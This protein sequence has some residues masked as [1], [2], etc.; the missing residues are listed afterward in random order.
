MSKLIS[1]KIKY[2]SIFKLDP[3]L[4]YGSF[5]GTADVISF[6]SSTLM[7]V[8]SNFGFETF[9]RFVVLPPGTNHGLY[10]VPLFGNPKQFSEKNKKK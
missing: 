2:T 6:M 3:P 4:E 1:K 8:I 9:G 5:I 7:T 10:L